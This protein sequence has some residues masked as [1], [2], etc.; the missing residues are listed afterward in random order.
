MRS[1]P[2][3]FLILL[4]SFL[5]GMLAGYHYRYGRSML[6]PLTRPYSEIVPAPDDG[7]PY[8]MQ[9]GD[10][11]VGLQEHELWNPYPE[12]CADGQP[13]ASFEFAG[14]PYIASRIY[15]VGEAKQVVATYTSEFGDAVSLPLTPFRYN[16]L[17]LRPGKL[18]ELAGYRK[19]WPGETLENQSELRITTFTAGCFGG[20]EEELFTIRPEGAATQVLYRSG[21]MDTTFLVPVPFTALHSAVQTGIREVGETGGGCV[22]MTYYG[23]KA[24]RQIFR[25]YNNACGHTALGRLL[26][27]LRSRLPL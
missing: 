16:E 10:I 25:S 23:V 5:L 7:H 26:R 9:P 18:D 17:V 27:D 1:T 11:L 20:S 3:I 24:G 2:G 14:G 21:S 12:I 19:L 4:V 8:T 22:Y 13:I 15:P 6:R